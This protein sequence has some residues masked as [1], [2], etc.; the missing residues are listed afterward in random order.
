[1]NLL[2]LTAGITTAIAVTTTTPVK[3]NGAPRNLTIQANFVYGSGGTSVDAYVQTSIDGGVTWCD[4]CN[5]HV[6][7]SSFRKVVN[8]NSQTAETTQVAVTDGSITANTAQDGILGTQLRVKYTSSGTYA[9]T[10]T[11]SIDCTSDQLV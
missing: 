7:T 6:T 8:L 9:G 4:I 10:T 2:N 3:L 1:M 5:F 11:L